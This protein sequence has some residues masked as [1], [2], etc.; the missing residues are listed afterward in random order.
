MKRI[1]MGVMAILLSATLLGATV[2]QTVA[3]GT[4]MK[5]PSQTTAKAKKP[6][7]EVKYKAACG[8]VYS[9]ADA[10]KY[11]YVCPM[12]HK[13]LVKMSAKVVKGKHKGK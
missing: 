13:P 1:T 5:P 8:M 4:S 11:K 2:I 3:Q 7:A 9:A 12:D 10:K 6:A